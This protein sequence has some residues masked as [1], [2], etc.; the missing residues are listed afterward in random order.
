MHCALFV[1]G[2]DHPVELANLLGP[3]GAIG[4]GI[5]RGPSFIRYSWCFWN[6]PASRAEISSRYYYY[7]APWAGCGFIVSRSL[8]HHAVSLQ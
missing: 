5:S 8:K 7:D 6:D 3:M 1:I 4:W 2:C